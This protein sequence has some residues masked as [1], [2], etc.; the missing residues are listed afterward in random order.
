[1]DFAPTYLVYRFFYRLSQFFHDWYVHG[2]R[3]AA[4]LFISLLERLDR[5]FA[6]KITALYFLSQF[7][8]RTLIDA[9][10]CVRTFKFSKP[11][12]HIVNHNFV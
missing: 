1:M 5:M 8:Q 3:N 10:A 7:N 11:V 9:G 4:H 12:N 6:V 2:S